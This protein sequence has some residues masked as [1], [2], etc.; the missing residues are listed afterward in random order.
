MMTYAIDTNI[1]LLDATNITTIGKAGD[2]IVIPEVCL[3]EVDSKKSGLTEVA[4][5]AREFGRLLSRAKKNG[6]VHNK[7][8]TTFTNY[9]LCDRIVCVVT[10][11]EYPSYRGLDRNIVNDRKIIDCILRYKDI[12]GRGENIIFLTNDV[13]C[14]IRAQSKGLATADLKVVEKVNYD[15]MKRLQIDDYEVFRNLHNTPIQYVDKEYELENYSYQFTNSVS[16]Q[17]KLASINNGIIN[18]LGKETE[19]KLRRQNCPPIGAEQLLASRAI[20]E[21]TIDLVVMEGKAGSGKAQPISEKILTPRGWKTMGEV[22]A[23]DAVIGSDG[24]PTLILDTFPQGVRPIYTVKFIDGT[25]VKCDID[26]IWTVRSSQKNM[27]GNVF[28]T[29]TVREML[30][31]WIAKERYD[32]RYD[33]YQ[34]RYNYSIPAAKKC[35]FDNGA[36]LPIDPYALGLLLGDGSFAGT[37]AAVSFSNGSKEICDRLKS[38][39]EPEYTVNKMK[40]SQG[41]WRMYIVKGT[42]K[43]TLADLLGGFDLNNKRSE[44]KHIPK[45]YLYSSL[46]NREALWQGLTDTD[47]YSKNKRLLEYTTSSEQLAEDYAELSRSIGKVVTVNSRIPKYRYNS[48]LLEGHKSYR[49]RQMKDK[50]KSIVSIE[51][52]HNEEAKCIMVEAKDSLYVTAG[53]NLTHNTLLA[54][55][56]LM[57]LMDTSKNAYDKIVYIRNPV[58]DVGNPDEEIGYLA[59]NSEKLDVYLGPMEDTLQFIVRNKLKKKSSERSA[60][61]E[62]RV[63]AE[64]VKLS[65]KYGIESMITL[66]LRGR[67]FTNSLIILD[68]CLHSDQK[69][70]TD[71]GL[72]TAV[73]LEEN[74][75]RGETVLM[76]SVN[77]Q[78]NEIEYK[79]LLT[80][81]KQHITTAKEKMY[82]LTMEDGSGIKVTGS[83]KVR[84]TGEW[85]TVD[86]IR[87]RIANG[88]TVEIND[89]KAH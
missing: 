59:G 9:T 40:F 12:V 74:M 44:E 55:S 80:L 25:E 66:G 19:D 69:V 39:L 10:M 57:R 63:A 22:E 42:A 70:R 65:G 56:S 24:K 51:F 61:Y 20:L 6:T 36:T 75:L 15:F 1:I 60:G 45:E 29:M 52:S 72:L 37:T 18:I 4:Y 33:S 83:H 58:D 47:G 48:E 11:D 30:K 82:E 2:T 64:I 26:H 23:G 53:F 38:L 3:D 85:V 14:G 62:D 46:V 86:E 78:T 79:P 27:Y 89:Y 88:E 32:K 71:K 31:D 5:Q 16:E 68:E 43:I 28:T 54:V 87:I 13:A 34:K 21:P 7:N 67:T 73:E 84:V 49:I 35:E 8:G 81:K 50:P 76:E 77:L 41:A 17:T